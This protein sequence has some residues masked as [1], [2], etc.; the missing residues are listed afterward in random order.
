MLPSARFLYALSACTK[1]PKNIRH[2][3][4]VVLWHELYAPNGFH[5]GWYEAYALLAIHGVCWLHSEDI[6][7]IWKLRRQHKRL[8]SH[9]WRCWRRW[10][11]V[12]SISAHYTREPYFRTVQFHILR[13]SQPRLGGWHWYVLVTFQIV[14]LRSVRKYWLEKAFVLL[15]FNYKSFVS[16]S[17]ESRE[18]SKRYTWF[19]F[20]VSFHSFLVLIL[21]MSCSCGLAS[22]RV[23][24][25]S[26]YPV[27]IWITLQKRCYMARG[28]TN[29]GLEQNPIS[30]QHS[31]ALEWAPE[32]SEWWPLCT[33]YLALIRISGA[34]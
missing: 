27:P 24:Q 25:K 10:Q 33:Y 22:R 5:D 20:H 21:I 11:W 17:E 9:S 23:R 34:D 1:S 15:R 13:L 19:H 6:S 32:S 30:L 29:D 3:Y 7:M 28:A 8:T 4:S 16:L 12:V 14:T 18:S 31:W 2:L 26:I